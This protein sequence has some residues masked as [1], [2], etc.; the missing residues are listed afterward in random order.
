MEESGER[1]YWRG[2]E[3]E[4]LCKSIEWSCSKGGMEFE[5]SEFDAGNGS[6]Y[7]VIQEGVI[8]RCKASVDIKL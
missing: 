7:C 6:L 1:D 3:E 2:C 8:C 5:W 4:W